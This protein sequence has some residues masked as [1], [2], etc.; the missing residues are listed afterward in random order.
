MFCIK[1]GADV[2]EGER[3]C[4]VCGNAVSESV[5]FTGRL[6]D[7]KPICASLSK[8]TKAYL[9]DIVIVLGLFLLSWSILWGYA[10]YALPVIFILYFSLTVAGEKSSTFGMRIQRI[11]VV[12]ERDDGRVSIIKAVIRCVLSLIFYITGIVFIKDKEGRRVVDMITG[13]RVVEI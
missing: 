13:T 5:V 9:I 10:V 7:D 3:I 12:D 1:C 11:K 6:N 4:P 2:R 8:Q